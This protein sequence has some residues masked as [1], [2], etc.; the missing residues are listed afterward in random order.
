MT[1]DE[2]VAKFMRLA[3]GVIAQKTAEKLVDRAMH[4]DTLDAGG[5]RELFQFAVL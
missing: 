1:D 4:F 3:E 5:V 2:V